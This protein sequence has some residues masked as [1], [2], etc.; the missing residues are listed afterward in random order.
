MDVVLSNMGRAALKAL[1]SGLLIVA[2]GVSHQT[3]LNGAVAVGIAGLIAIG[4]AVLAAVQ[5]YIPALSVKAYIPAPWGPAIDSFI[6]AALPYFLVA[7]IGILNE[8]DMAAWKAA[9]V[10]AIVGAVNAGLRAIQGA[11]TPGD[12]P[13][14]GG[15]LPVP[16][17]PTTVVDPAGRKRVVRQAPVH[18]AAAR[19]AA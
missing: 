5:T 7:V 4:A 1:L 19:L 6:H 9:I 18:P 12:L 16:A 15:G 2:I 13:S 14:I 8:P 3:N 17:Q 11:A 10:A